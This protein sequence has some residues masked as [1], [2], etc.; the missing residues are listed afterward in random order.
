MIEKKIKE[1]LFH[2]IKQHTNGWKKPLIVRACAV[3][4]ALI[5]CSFIIVIFTKHNPIEVFQALI[6]GAIGHN[7]NGVMD[8]LQKTAILLCISLGKG[9]AKMTF[10][11]SDSKN[12]L[13]QLPLL[14]PV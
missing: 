5:V 7:G 12:G 1:P 14:T 6:T 8:L 4:I 3:L 2:I 9:A 10:H 13:P 11:S